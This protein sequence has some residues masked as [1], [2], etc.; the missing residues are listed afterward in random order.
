MNQLRG[1][2]SPLIGAIVVAGSL[3]AVPL[4]GA[5]G[6]PPI[7]N[8]DAHEVVMDGSLQA[9]ATWHRPGW[10]RRSTLT[11][12]N[13]SRGPLVD[14]PILVTL[15]ASRIDY[16]R[17]QRGGQDLRFVD[18]NGSA[19][20]HEI[21]RWN[22]AGTSSVWVRV[23]VVDSS[24]TDH[25]YVYYGNDAAP[26]AQ[27]PAGVWSN[28]YVG[29]W[30]LDEDPGSGPGSIRDS[31]AFA[32][33]GD[34]VNLDASNRQPGVVG[35]GLSFAGLAAPDADHVRIPSNGVDALSITG[36]ALTLEAWVNRSGATGQWQIAVGRQLGTGSGDAFSLGA[37]FDAPT[38]MLFGANDSLISGNGAIP[39]NQWRYLVGVR[40]GSSMYDYV[41]GAEV[42]QLTGLVSTIATDANDV[43]IGGAE[44]GATATVDEAWLGR[45]DE[46]RISNVARSADWVEAQ[47]ASMTD[48]LLTY[49]GPVE[50]GVLVN[51]TDT[52]FD[53]LV[54]TLV[55]GPTNAA[56][57]SLDPDGSFDYTPNPG[58]TGTDSFT[59]TAADGTSTS[60]PA[61][62]S[63]TVY[64]E[65]FVVNATGDA[66]DSTIGDGLCRTGNM[67]GDAPECTLRA[68]IGEANAST[69]LDLIDFSIPTSD[70]G[71]SASPL[72][73]TLTPAS[74][75]PFVVQPVVIDATTQ[76]GHVDRPVIQLDG[77]VAA[78]A[79]G[80]LILRTN[81]SRITGFIVHSF[82]D[83]GLEIDGS[84]GF[85]DDNVISG[86]WVGFDA[87]WAAGPNADMG[88]LV[89]HAAVG[90][91]IQGN[92]VGNSGTSGIGV[93]VTGTTGNTVSGN[94][95][96]VGPDG[97]TAMPNTQHGIRISETADGNTVGGVA[98]EDAN[99]IAFN[100]GDGIHVAADAGSG[101]ALLGN[102]LVGNVGLGID[103]AGGTENGFGVTAN[104]PGDLGPNDLL[105]HPVVTAASVVSGMVTVDFDFEA[106]A[107]DYRIEAFTNP[108]G[109]DDSG[110]GEGERFEGGDDGDTHRVGNREL[111]AGLRRIGRRP[112]HPH[113]N[114]TV[115]RPDPRLDLGVLG[116]PGGRSRRHDLGHRVRGHRGR[117]ARRW[118][119]RRCRQP[120]LARRHRRAVRRRLAR[121]HRH[122]R[123]DRCL[124]VRR[125]ARWQL[126]GAD[127]LDHDSLGP[128]PDRAD[129]RP[130]GRADLRT[131]RSALCRRCGRCVAERRRRVLLRRR[132]PGDVGRRGPRLPQAP[133]AGLRRRRSCGRARLRVL[134]QRGHQHPGR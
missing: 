33:D 63:I 61:T 103:L 59:Y 49:G 92:V 89:T 80:A 131:A 70:P 112:R 68:A 15:D 20:D 54:A 134:V 102:S 11:I 22:E 95:I 93:R 2:L 76:P 78:G 100:L 122:H 90:N 32:N 74:Q 17:T 12:A 47:H 83:E 10:D 35:S 27:N 106:P 8:D 114:R 44:N 91:R 3:A 121:R 42:A 5:S 71:H 127:R 50:P 51:D 69:T 40:D 65:R 98:A 126:H 117:P 39:A 41:D 129:R 43:V 86:N 28:G 77:R 133:S 67:V 119:D 88:I 94:L 53:A 66:I 123:L 48:T 7:A 46:V 26:D 16:G 58:F 62:V 128:G 14:V 120:G 60:S 9:D 97:V 23:P 38:Q 6:A 84:T 82:V 31:T 36:T 116:G 13:A 18:A 109:A 105:D 132:D 110:H 64:D 57:F 104:D 111:P 52:E 30:H 1:R 37:K 99:T 56:S 45:M 85:G 25:F 81:D 96:G 24:D 130:L 79:S 19:L 29:V 107:G 4:V 118:G 87:D 108:S 34:P 125:R 75:L 72:V 124:R 113:R 115:G 21:E 55:A 101:N 73:Y